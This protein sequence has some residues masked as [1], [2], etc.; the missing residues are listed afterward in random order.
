VNAQARA[1]FSMYA[2]MRAGTAVNTDVVTPVMTSGM[3]TQDN[4]VT[5][6]WLRLKQSTAAI[7][8]AATT[9]PK[10]YLTFEKEHRLC[11]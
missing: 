10:K 6:C 9:W 4:N 8:A 3:N 11:A 5:R 7:M 1:C 2:V